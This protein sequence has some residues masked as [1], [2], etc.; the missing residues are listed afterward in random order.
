MS[1]P[2]LQLFEQNSFLS[3]LNY[4]NFKCDLYINKNDPEYKTFPKVAMNL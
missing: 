2:L 1:N 3:A 4:A